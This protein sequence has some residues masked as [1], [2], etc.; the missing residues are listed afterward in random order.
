MTPRSRTYVE[1]GVDPRAF[2]FA[3][4]A[5]ALCHIALFTALLMV[6]DLMPPKK[7]TPETI[8]VTMVSLPAPGPP[9]GKKAPAGAKAKKP[10]PAPKKAPVPPK[11]PLPFKTT[12]PV[13]LPPVTPQPIVSKPTQKPKPKTSLK[14]KTFKPE[15]VVKQSMDRVPKKVDATG[16]DRRPQT[17]DPKILDQLATT[18]ANQSAQRETDQTEAPGGSGQDLGVKGGSQTPGGR[19]AE[20][21][22]IYRVEIAQQVKQN[23]AFSDQLA[24]QGKDWQASLVFKVM[25]NGQIHDVFFTDRSGNKYLDESAERAV[26]KSNPVNPHPPG[27]LTPYVQVGLRFTPEGVQ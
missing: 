24:G 5:S 21:I 22:D 20:I 2:G 23:W 13:V 26:M 3:V 15:N 1:T 17:L 25:P 16:K 18:V 10:S 8:Y 9:A 4:V 14:K 27:I 19:S 7:H 6:P 11:K 12:R